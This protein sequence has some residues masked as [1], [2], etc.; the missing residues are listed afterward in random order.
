MSFFAG[1]AIPLAPLAAE[2]KWTGAIADVSWYSA[3]VTYVVGVG[4]ASKSKVAP[5]YAMFG[6]CL[7]AVFYGAD[8]QADADKAPKAFSAIWA[9]GGVGIAAAFYF[10]ERIGIHLANNRSFPE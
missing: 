7:L 10:I 3:G 2:W 1:I 6:A 5:W 4:L 8:L 9:R